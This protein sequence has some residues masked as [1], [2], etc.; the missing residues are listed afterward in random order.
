MKQ[1]LKNHLPPLIFIFLLSS[2]FWIFSGAPVLNF[3]LLFLGLSLGAFFLDTDHLLYWYFLKP[4]LGESKNAR[5]LISQKRYRDVLAHLALYHKTH[6][7]LIFHHFTFQ[8]I[9]LI[10]T[11][12]VLSSTYTIF[13]KG[14][15]L[16]IYIHLLV[17]QINDYKKD[18]AHLKVWLFARSPLKPSTDWVKKY[19]IFYSAFVPFFFYLLVSTR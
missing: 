11:F 4:E 6:T 12:F 8:V 19:L 15:C 10:L 3:I 18:P 2:L 9:L 1:E 7:S 13:G 17:D 5:I 14:L 16:S